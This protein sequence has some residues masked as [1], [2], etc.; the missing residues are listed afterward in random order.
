MCVSD[1]HDL[2]HSDAGMETAPTCCVHSC[3]SELVGALTSL[4][5]LAAFCYSKTNT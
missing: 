4:W 2:K 3:L 5:N 1:L